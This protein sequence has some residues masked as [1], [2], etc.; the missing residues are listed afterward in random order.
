ML[1]RYY[2]VLFFSR[3]INLFQVA[4]KAV[5][6]GGCY[7][8]KSMAGLII[9]CDLLFMDPVEGANF[10]QNDFTLDSTQHEVLKISGNR[11]FDVVLSDMAP[12]ASGI[13]S[14][15]HDKII[16][17]SYK[18]LKFA[19]VHSYP[20]SHFVTKIW[21]GHGRDKLLGDIAK[22]YAEA[23]VIK[24]KASRTDSAEIYLA[25]FNFKGLQK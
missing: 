4:S 14:M 1:V 11:K 23:Q 6:A 18:A 25:G 10:I 24:P 21:A 17:L 8:D 19:L 7:S 15:D 16:D 20:G 3:V 2:C 22:F 13:T 12:N 9:G 5:N